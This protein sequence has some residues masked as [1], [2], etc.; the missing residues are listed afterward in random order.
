MAL[1]IAARM[2]SAGVTDFELTLDAG[3]ISLN[4][5]APDGPLPFYIGEIQ[6]LLL[7]SFSNNR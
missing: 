5:M 1:A 7:R 4:R 6:M 2:D 3:S